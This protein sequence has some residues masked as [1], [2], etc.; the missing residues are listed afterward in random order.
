MAIIEDLK[1]HFNSLKAYDNA[2]VRRYGTGEGNIDQILADRVAIE[3][4]Q[5]F[6]TMGNNDSVTLKNN[7]DKL[8]DNVFPIFAP[9]SRQFKDKEIVI[10]KLAD[11]EYS[12]QYICT[13]KPN[14]N[15]FAQLSDQLA[16]DGQL[17][18]NFTDDPD[19]ITAILALAPAEF[20]V[21]NQDSINFA[22]E[23]MREEAKIKL[24]DSPL[25]ERNVS[26]YEQKIAWINT[27]ENYS[28]ILAD[29]ATLQVEEM[30]DRVYSI[31][32]QSDS[33][34]L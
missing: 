13:V 17:L 31:T 8:I 23:V 25:V 30:L 18:A 34:E 24:M 2:I 22:L 26:D 11:M 10:D 7:S 20:L 1:A 33:M 14:E 6:F 32:G 12:N 19:I 9:H 15:T 28:H 21:K 16:H 5:P 29:N 3:M 27:T 4:I